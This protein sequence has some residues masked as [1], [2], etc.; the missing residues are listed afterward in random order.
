MERTDVHRFGL[1]V[2]RRD[3][4]P[5][6]LART[7]RYRARPVSERRLEVVESGGQPGLN[8]ADERCSIKRIREPLVVGGSPIIEIGREVLVRVAPPLGTVD[9]DLLAPQP[10]PQ[11]LQGADLERDPVHPLPT[12]AIGHDDELPPP[13]WHNLDRHDLIDRVDRTGPIDRPDDQADRR[14]DRAVGHVR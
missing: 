7:D 8:V 5:A 1:R 9:P 4:D 6:A 12:L 3:G 14:E 10:I 13:G 2:E 11:G